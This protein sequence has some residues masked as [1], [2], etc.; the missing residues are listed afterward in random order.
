MRNDKLQIVFIFR[1]VSNLVNSK[2][3]SLLSLFI[4]CTGYTHSERITHNGVLLRD[5]GV[6]LR[7]GTFSSFALE[8]ESPK[9][10]IYAFLVSNMF[11]GTVF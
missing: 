11:L 10:T 5:S 8:C 2:D 1:F 4:C 3:S 7:E 9:C 6:H